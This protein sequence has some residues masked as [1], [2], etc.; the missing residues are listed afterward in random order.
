MECQ[1][2]DSAEFKFDIEFPAFFFFQVRVV[3]VVRVPLLRSTGHHRYIMR[4]E[5]HIINIEIQG[6]N[7]FFPFFLFN[8]KYKLRVNL[9]C[10]IG[11]YLERASLSF[12]YSA[13]LWKHSQK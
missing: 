7:L 2:H 8:K 10:I 12:F 5:S 3:R 11:Q 9:Q 4:G 13:L 1:G 6:V